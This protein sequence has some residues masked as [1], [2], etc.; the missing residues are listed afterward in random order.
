M[1]DTNNIEQTVLFEGAS[2]HDVY[3]LLM[4]QSKFATLSGKP[5]E[6]SRAVGGSVTAY[7]GFVKA[8]NVE[9]VPDTRIVQAWK[10]GIAQWPQDHHSVVAFAL[11]K[12][13]QGTQLSFT[14]VGVP[15]AGFDIVVAGWPQA[16]WDPMKKA[17]GN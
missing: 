11:Q 2:P 8:I 12:V 9:L 15:T 13:P 7:G 6:I 5:A 3:E 4:D 17:L 10:G 14:Q 1:I 16:Y